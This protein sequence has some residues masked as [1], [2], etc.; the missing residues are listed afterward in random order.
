MN[1]I[2][3]LSLLRTVNTYAS[4]DRYRKECHD[5]KRYHPNG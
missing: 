2:K 4:F 1:L 5:K 3:D